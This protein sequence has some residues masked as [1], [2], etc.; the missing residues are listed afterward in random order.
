MRIEMDM[1]TRHFPIGAMG[2]FEQARTD[3]AAVL[4]VIEE[5][6]IM[7]VPEETKTP[8]PCKQ[9]AKR[10]SPIGAMGTFNVSL[11]RTTFCSWPERSQLCK[12][13]SRQACQQ[14]SHSGDGSF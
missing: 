8:P 1:S 4:P 3:P 11:E 2:S 9:R 12:R 13:E 14:F 7:T 5:D 6:V 10:E